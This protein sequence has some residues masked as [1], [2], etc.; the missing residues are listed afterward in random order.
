[1]KTFTINTLKSEI[2]SLFNNITV[3]VSEINW[4]IKKILLNIMTPFTA[5]QLQVAY[6]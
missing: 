4:E 6:A 3:V 2:D 5:P 1:M